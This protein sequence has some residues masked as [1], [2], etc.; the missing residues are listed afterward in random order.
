M[1][2]VGVASRTS[3]RHALSAILYVCDIAE[4]TMR[5]SSTIAP[6]APECDSLGKWPP[7][8]ARGKTRRADGHNPRWG[9]IARQTQT[10]H[11]RRGSKTGSV[12]SA[13]RLLFRSQA[14]SG[15]VVTRGLR[16]GVFNDDGIIHGVHDAI[17]A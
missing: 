12:F 8:V 13:E 16:S 5:C 17:F 11:S 15:V 4:A 9:H 7:E 2:L 6:S 10:G 1:I 3:Y 14:G